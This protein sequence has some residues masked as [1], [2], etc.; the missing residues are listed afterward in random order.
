VEFSGSIKFYDLR[1]SYAQPRIIGATYNGTCYTGKTLPLP[2]TNDPKPQS[3]SVNI[4]A[5]ATR[6]FWGSANPVNKSTS[7]STVSSPLIFTHPNG[8][9]GIFEH[10]CLTTPDGTANDVSGDNGALDDPTLPPL[11]IYGPWTICLSPWSAERD[12]NAQ[13]DFST[14]T[15]IQLGFAGTARVI[16]ENA[17]L[18]LTRGHSTAHAA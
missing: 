9:D 7:P 3:I 17:A 12:A 11:G 13:I 14:V 5:P 15:Q 18:T 6:W 16:P 10:Y 1:A 2:N 8:R 4:H